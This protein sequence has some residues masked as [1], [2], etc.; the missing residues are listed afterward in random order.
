MIFTYALVLLEGDDNGDEIR[1]GKEM[2]MMKV[3]DMI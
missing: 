2:R 3:D 1:K